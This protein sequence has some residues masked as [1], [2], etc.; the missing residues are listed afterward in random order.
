MKVSEYIKEKGILKIS[1]LCNWD[2]A[3]IK[4]HLLRETDIEANSQLSRIMKD[5]K[6][7]FNEKT[8]HI[9]NNYRIK[10]IKEK[11]ERNDYDI[12]NN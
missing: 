6:N 1:E 12:T 11:L 9:R 8:K 5:F 7:F 4:Y 3:D 10:E 2:I